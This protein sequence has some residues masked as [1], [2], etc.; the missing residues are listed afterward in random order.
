MTLPPREQRKSQR[1]RCRLPVDLSLHGRVRRMYTFDVSRHG[2]FVETPEIVRER[3]LVQ[4]SIQLPDGPL[5]ATSSVSR[6]VGPEA[7]V[8]GLGLQLFAISLAAKERWDRFVHSLG[9]DVPSAPK[10][11]DAASFLVKLPS[12]ARLRE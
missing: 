12:L 5:N 7:S 9:G 6:R 8:Q 1:H 2:L 10:G 4:T 3:F 11:P